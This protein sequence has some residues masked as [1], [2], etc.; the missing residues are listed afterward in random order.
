VVQNLVV[1]RKVVAGDDV[2]T[3]IL[4]QLPVSSTE[5]LSSLEQRL[6][7]DLSAPVSFGGFLELTVCYTRGIDISECKDN[8]GLL[9]NEPPMRG[10]PRTDLFTQL[11]KHF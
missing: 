4:L 2:G 5:R 1:E 9:L 7:R 6:L 10:N 11:A 3:G 8:V